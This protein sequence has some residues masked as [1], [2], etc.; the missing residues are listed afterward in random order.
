MREDV[1]TPE[2]LEDEARRIRRVRLLVD[3]ASSLIMQGRLARR[4]A[5]ALV[6]LVR[7]RVLELFPG[8]EGTFDIVYSRRFGRLIDEFSGADPAQASVVIPFPR[9]S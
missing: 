8:S 6:G 5:E 1:P 4:E 3:S 2:Q 7:Q 9:R